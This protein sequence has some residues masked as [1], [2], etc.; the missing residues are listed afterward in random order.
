M[1]LWPHVSRGYLHSRG[2]CNLGLGAYWQHQ[3]DD[4][5]RSIVWEHRVPGRLSI[6]RTLH[7]RRRQRRH[8]HAVSPAISSNFEPHS[9]DICK[10]FHLMSLLIQML[11]NIKSHGLST[12]CTLSFSR[13]QIVGSWTRK[14]TDGQRVHLCSHQTFHS[15]KRSIST[16]TKKTRKHIGSMRANIVSL[17]DRKNTPHCCSEGNIVAERFCS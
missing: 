17:R 14:S 10:A 11:H 5:A 9:S 16:E 3:A 1:L 6:G 2:L 8:G 12:A 4:W 15:F 7:Q 13:G